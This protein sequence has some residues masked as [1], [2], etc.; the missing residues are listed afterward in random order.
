[1]AKKTELDKLDVEKIIEEIKE[2]DVEE[3]EPEKPE[4][5]K[6]K[7][8]K[9]QEKPEEKKDKKKLI[10]FGIIVFLGIINLVLAFLCYK[11]ATKKIVIKSNFL[12]INPK[13]IYIT[14]EKML[15]AK[16]EQETKTYNF[17]F[18]MGYEFNGVNSKRILTCQVTCIFKSK[19]QVDLNNLYNYI[20]KKV[21]EDFKKLVDDKFL[22]EIPNYEAKLSVIIEDNIIKAI[23]KACPDVN[24]NELKKVINFVVFRIK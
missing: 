7:E 10:F 2:E 19:Y 16:I 21:S 22:E 5:K 8:N 3:K 17:N 1:M 11:Q 24:E 13:V 12:K 9:P 4:E 6:E 14:K 15:Q 23:I 18:M 20:A